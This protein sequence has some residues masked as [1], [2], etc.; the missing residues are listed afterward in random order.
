MKKIY[1]GL[2]VSLMTMGSYAQNGLHFEGDD[3]YVST[4]FMPPTG[5]SARTVETWVKMDAGGQRFICNWGNN[6][7]GENFSIAINNGKIK[8]D[9]KNETAQGALSVKDG[10][11][12][13]IAVTY[14]DALA[15]DKMVCYIDGVQDFTFDPTGT[16]NTGTDN[17]LFIG[18]R[19]S[20]A[21]PFFK[22]EIDELKI[23]D[24]ARTQAEIQADMNNGFCGTPS[25]LVFYHKFDEGVA[26]GS[27]PTVTTS[28][29][30][31]GNGNDGTLIGFALTGTI[32]N[33]VAGQTMAGGS[34]NTTHTVTACG[35]YTFD[36][37]AYT[38][39]NNTAVA[40]LTSVNGCDSIVTLDLTINDPVD[41]STTNNDP[42]I[43]ANATA[44]TFRWLDCDDN[45]S[46]IA[47]ETN[48]LFVATANGNYAV[49]V[50]QNGCVDTSDCVNV[51]TIGI[52][53]NNF[54]AEFSMYP[55]PS[56]GNF[57]IEFAK[58]HK[59]VTVRLFSSSGQLI[60]NKVF[61]NS[62]RINLE[63]KHPAGLYFIEVIDADSNRAMGRLI[64]E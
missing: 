45:N 26:D 41:V 47:G 51:M 53:E 13:H 28:P 9:L 61:Q 3:D 18:V 37:T 21:A 29:D 58:S 5:N 39:S 64:L 11:W 17:P 56:K 30:A 63:F 62:N 35:S 55:N 44:A 1:L 32:S 22:G 23:W 24:Y 7:T 25:G 38:T 8:V 6:A 10:T 4:N 31:S 16:V 42:S 60:E 12:H 48:A 33:W 46:V 54:A 43:T 52:N 15:S 2:L 50:T 19:Y 49:E 57:T 34:I 27:N 40:N 36:G 20:V 59:E 14:D